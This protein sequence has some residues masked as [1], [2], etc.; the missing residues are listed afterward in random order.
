[1]SEFTEILQ[2]AETGDLK[3]AGDLLPIV[4]EELRELAARHLAN[5]QPGQTLQPTALVHEAYVRLAGGDNAPQWNGRRHFMAAAA[6]AIRRILVDNARRKNSLKR[7]GGAVRQDLHEQIAVSFAEPVEDL[8]AL[9]EALDKLEQSNPQA[10]QL[11]Q[12]LYFSGL[13]RSQ[14]AETLGIS[15]RTADRLWTY[16]RA[17]LRREMRGSQQPGEE[18]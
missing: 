17:W 2:A 5:E 16:A 8:L 4:Y 7:G 3:A 14:A 10:A 11:V 1:M 18:F 12:L 13:S 9:D 6:I 15:T